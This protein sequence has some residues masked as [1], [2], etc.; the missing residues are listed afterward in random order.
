MDTKY[1][2]MT[3]LTKLR[4]HIVP[5]GFEIDRVVLP[6][7]KYKADMVWMIVE[8]KPFKEKTAKFIKNI[9]SELKNKD[10]KYDFERC[11]RKDL[12]AIINAIKTV[13]KK[14]QNND[15]YVN[16]SAGS[17]IQAIACMMA[18]MMFKEYNANPYYVE[19]KNYAS[20]TMGEP[21]SVGLKD[22][23]I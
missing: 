8:K 11:N 10:I 5:V 20:E 1:T 9:E 13:F 6:A 16:V 19:P 17:K 18:C 15:L 3:K 4:I 7:I 14:E 12:F 22:I 23:I 21:Q 2:N